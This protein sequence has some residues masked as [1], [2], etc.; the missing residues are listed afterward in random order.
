[1]VKFSKPLNHED[2]RITTDFHDPKRPILVIIRMASQ[3]MLLLMVML[4]IQI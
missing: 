2:M 3:F 1:M 4:Y